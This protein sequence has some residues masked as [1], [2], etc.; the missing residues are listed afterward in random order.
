MFL[1]MHENSYLHFINSNEY[2]PL[3]W[4]KRILIYETGPQITLSMGPG[5]NLLANWS[6]NWIFKEN[7]P[8]VINI[9]NFYSNALTSN[10]T[11][12]YCNIS[13]KRLHCRFGKVQ[14]S[15]SNPEISFLSQ[16]GCSPPISLTRMAGAS[17]ALRV[18]FRIY[19]AHCSLT[20]LLPQGT[21]IT[22]LPAGP[23]TKWLLKYKTD[24][25]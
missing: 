18:G 10:R 8:T 13:F 2:P 3:H 9:L 24:M 20:S 5:C 4:T 16:K 21:I 12:N 23:G 22:T 1:M 6:Q 17:G 14:T 19:W 11:P 15:A 25:S 7:L